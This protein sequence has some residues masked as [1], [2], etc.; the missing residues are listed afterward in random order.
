MLKT[1]LFLFGPATS[2]A[3]VFMFGLP[4]L[5]ACAVL[6]LG[7]FLLSTGEADESNSGALRFDQDAQHLW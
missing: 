7:T 2:A 5:I 6:A 3:L 1:F 4:V